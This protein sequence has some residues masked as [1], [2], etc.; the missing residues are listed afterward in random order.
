MNRGLHAELIDNLPLLRMKTS[1]LPK[2]RKEVNILCLV[3]NISKINCFRDYYVV[4]DGSYLLATA[5]CVL[6]PRHH[7][8]AIGILLINGARR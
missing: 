8:Q 2:I 1:L 3:S 6:M 4:E 5:S 7:F